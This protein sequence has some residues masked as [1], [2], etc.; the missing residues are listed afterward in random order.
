MGNIWHK[1]NQ[2]KQI[3]QLLR[4]VLSGSET[5]Y[6]SG[7]VLSLQ[8][9]IFAQIRKETK[10]PC[11]Y[12]V[13]NQLQATKAYEDLATFL[14]K[15]KLLIFPALEVLPYEVIARSPENAVQR[16]KVLE[17]LIQEDDLVVIAPIQAVLT[18][19][20][21]PLLMKEK[22]LSL[23]IGT[24]LNL[25]QTIKT[26][27][28][29]GYERVELVE[30]VGQFAVRG[31]I[32]DVYPLVSHYPIRIELFDDEVDSIREFNP[33]TQRSLN[34]I[35]KTFIFPAREGL[36]AKIDCEKAKDL[37]RRDFN[38]LG[39]KLNRIG[40][41]SALSNLRGKLEELLRQ[42][43]GD[44]SF[45]NLGDYLPYYGNLCSLAEYFACD[46][47]IWLEEPARTRDAMRNWQKEVGET[48][49]ELL[50]EGLVL[51]KQIELYFLEDSFNF[52]LKKRQSVLSSFLTQS[53]GD[54]E[55]NNHYSLVSQPVI[56]FYGKLEL[57]WQELFLWKQRHYQ[58]VIV[59]STPERG[60]RLAELFREREIFPV[61]TEDLG[62]SLPEGGVLIVPGILSSGFNLP[63]SEL[64]LI[65]DGEIFSQV[66]KKQPKKIKKDGTAI[67]RLEDLAVGDY[68]VHETQGIGRYLGVETLVVNGAKR[69]YLQIKYANQDKLYLPTEQLNKAQKYVG[70]EGSVPKLSRLGG[71][72]WVKLKKK[73][74][75]SVEQL[76]GQLLRLYALRATLERPGCSPDTV[77]QLEFEDSFPFTETPDQLQAI[78]E[79]KRDLESNRPMDRLLC[80]D[81]GYG[82][83]EVAIR[84]AF[85]MAVEGRQTAV[86]VPTTILAEQHGQTFGERFKD[87]PITVEVLNRFR[88]PKEQ[89]KIVSKLK[90]GAVDVVIGTHRLLQKDIMFHNLGLLIIDEEQRFGVSHKEK[91]KQLRTNIDVLTLT[92]TPIP[93]TLYMSLMGVRDISVIDTPPEDR[94]PVQTF[95]VEYNEGLIRDVILREIG[96]GGQVYFVHNRVQTIERTV[97]R[98]QKLI[99]EAR[100][101]VAHGQMPEDGLE[102]AMLEFFEGEQ[103]VLVCTTIIETGLDLP[104]VNTLII[105]H[106]DQMGLAQLYQLRGRVGRSNRTA[107]AYLT[108]RPNQA[109]SETAEK[110]L[111]AI[112]EF[113]DFG[114]G[115]KIAMRDLEIR[116]AGNLLGS[117]QHG[118]IAAIGFGLYCR[119]LEDAMR[120]LKGEKVKQEPEPIIELRVDAYLPEDY[121]GDNKQKMEIYKRIADLEELGEVGDIYDELLDRFGDLPD[122]AI[123][124]LAVAKLKLLAKKLA[125]YQLSQ[126]EENV[127]LKFSDNQFL[128]C[129]DFPKISQKYR[130]NLSF[131][132]GKNLVCSVNVRGLTFSALLSLLEQILT[133]FLG[134]CNPDKEIEAI[135]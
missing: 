5:Q 40:K 22:C 76:A 122:A 75:K 62:Y 36:A 14:P 65:S 109:I 96:R 80:G 91:I 82:K 8:R 134:N 34:E 124:L 94:F 20:V 101:G 6:L 105:D 92:A 51:P 95:V 97:F 113:T 107:Y 50:K 66:K 69:D 19:L 81:V 49:L 74:K 90:S 17:R 132:P 9:M 108:Y 115:Y 112:K 120:E 127:L 46:S 102:Q 31:G 16:L 133:D 24:S 15:E 71:A 128:A 1:L 12:I 114:S 4:G 59:V 98:L 7:S 85:K 29:L 87:F 56:S 43:E 126:E 27:L 73:V 116:G 39:G 77:W 45:P 21:S 93:R 130:N 10:K 72:D 121:I 135:D 103:D 32:I 47:L 123:S 68:I 86:L 48:H 18:K 117:E 63:E 70:A 35:G 111:Q 3:N 33:L 100:F 58:T 119:M 55:I 42:M 106:A 125:I 37:I 38:R 44:L 83:T 25:E 52:I 54:L 67:T 61:L 79:I 104:N 99:P 84:S 88:S 30:T 23:E 129:A 53:L 11:L 28:N 26:M 60:Q 110:R 57:F 131:I 118:H 2:N 41:K 13:E 64:A 89:K 78:R